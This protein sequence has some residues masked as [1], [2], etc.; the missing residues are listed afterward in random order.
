MRQG[1]CGERK[2]EEFGA[3]LDKMLEHLPKQRYHKVEELIAA[4]DALENG[5]QKSSNNQTRRVNVKQP[6]T[7]QKKKTFSF[8]TLTVNKFGRIINSQRREAE[9][10]QEDLGKGVRLEMV[11]I[12]GGTFLMGSPSNEEERRKSE[13]PQHKVNVSTFYMGR[14]AVTQAQWQAIM[15]NNPARFKGDNR[16]VEEVSWLEAVEFCEKLS[17]KLGKKYR[18]PSEAEWEYA[19]RAGTTTAFHFGITITTDLANYDGSSTYA[20]APEGEYR[21]ETTEVGSFP[22]N[23]FGLYDM[24]SNVWEWCYDQWHDS[25]D[26]APTDGNT[27]LIDNSNNHSRLIRGGSWAFDPGNCRSASRNHSYPDSYLGSCCFRLVCAAA[28]IRFFPRFYPF[29]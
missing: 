8:E 21:G 27:W 9:Y 4:V 11:K 15:G 5:Q 18:L 20:S 16:P 28:R 17:E 22:P 6:V 7:H 24:H 3:I 13:G 23:T 12:P 1:G 2:E 10:I 14:Y 29:A 26:G 25:Y 19:C